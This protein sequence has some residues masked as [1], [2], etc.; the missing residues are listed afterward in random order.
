VKGAQLAWNNTRVT[1]NQQIAPG[2]EEVARIVT[3]LL[4]RLPILGLP[5][6]D[7]R[8]A[9]E[10]GRVV[11]AEVARPEPDRGIVRRGLTA[12]KGALAELAAG[13]VTGANAGAVEV[14]KDLVRTLGHLGF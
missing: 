5:E 3:D 14:G 11:L 7:A 13:L 8:D 10:H 1:Q 9:A 4:N 6:P 2:F 12:I